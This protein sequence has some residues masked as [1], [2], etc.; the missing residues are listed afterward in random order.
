MKKQIPNFISSF[1]ILLIPPILFY[2]LKNEYWAAWIA[3]VLFSLAGLS[4]YFDGYY[5]RKYQWVT[6][7]G[8][9]LDPI[10]DKLLV[11]AGLIGLL[12]LG[13]IHFIL[14]LPVILR[15]I[16]VDGL[17][18]VAASENVVISAGKLGKWKTAIQL[19]AM[20]FLFFPEPNMDLFPYC[21]EA[22]ISGLIIGLILSLVSGTEYV[23]SYI[24]NK[25]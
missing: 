21:E 11:T 6:T 10:A 9:F 15:D 8:K 16:I 12:V 24:K 22:A 4:D 7:L 14:V 20:P 5:A 13:K 19:F 1:R 25:A 2:V 23:V 3:V 17:R 18:A